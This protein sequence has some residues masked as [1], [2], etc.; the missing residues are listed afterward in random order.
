M[1]S[2]GEI[3]YSF[4]FSFQIFEKA[5]ASTDIVQNIVFEKDPFVIFN[6]VIMCAPYFF[7]Y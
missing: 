4:F 6:E 1:T 2:D 5:V 3:Q 7:T